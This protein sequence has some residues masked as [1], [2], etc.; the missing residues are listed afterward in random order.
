[1]D[2]VRRSYDAVAAEYARRISGELDGKPLDRALLD[3]FAE[4]AAPLGPVGDLG[5]GPAHVGAYLAGRGC[6]VV[7]VD[8]SPGLL[9]EG[10]RRFPAL[11]LAAGDLRALPLRDGA[12]GGAAALYT[13]IHLAAADWPVALAELRR[14]LAPGGLLLAAVHCGSETVHLDDWWGQAVSV[15]FHFLEPAE[16]Q[17]RVEVAGFAVE[18]L[19]TR[20]PY[21]G[22][23]HASR[24]AYLLARRG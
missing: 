10:R 4:Q 1:M 19:L 16:L 18:A 9:A 22:V 20:A 17:R 11:P 21:P 5:C 7:G 6:R 14:V 24:R 13:L 23:E 2:D 8:L 3:A 12:L 15:D